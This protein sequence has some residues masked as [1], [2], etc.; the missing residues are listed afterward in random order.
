MVISNSE[1]ATYLKSKGKAIN[2]S[3]SDDDLSSNSDSSSS[4][5]GHVIFYDFVSSINS[6]YDFQDI[7]TPIETSEDESNAKE[8]L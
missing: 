7:H 5:E 6:A 2:A 1:W 4:F 3:L 8:S